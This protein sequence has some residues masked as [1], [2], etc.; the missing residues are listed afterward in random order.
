M[1]HF[2]VEKCDHCGKERR[3]REGGGEGEGGVFTN[4]LNAEER[5]KLAAEEWYM[6]HAPGRNVSLCPTCGYQVARILGALKP[7]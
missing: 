6:F 1:S 3:S 2:Y 4:H 7:L 5:E